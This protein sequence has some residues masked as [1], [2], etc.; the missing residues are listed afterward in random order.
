ME[1]GLGVP[2]DI[3]L[4]VFVQFLEAFQ[5]V[6]EG[7]IL[8]CNMCCLNIFEMFLCQF[9]VFSFFLNRFTLCHPY[10]FFNFLNVF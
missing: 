3:A 9:F 7:H 1:V 6:F 5:K 2:V 4:F 10:M 8:L